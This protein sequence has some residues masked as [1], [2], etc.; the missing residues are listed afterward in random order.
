[1]AC[2]SKHAAGHE[3]E[4]QQCSFAA[5]FWREK[6]NPN[7]DHVPESEWAKSIPCSRQKRWFV[8]P[9]ADSE[10]Q[11]PYP[12][13][14]PIWEYPP[15]PPGVCVCGEGGRSVGRCCARYIPAH[16]SPWLPSC[17][18]AWIVQLRSCSPPLA[19]RGWSFS[20]PPIS[21]LTLD[22]EGACLPS[23]TRHLQTKG[24]VEF[25]QNQWSSF[26]SHRTLDNEIRDT[27]EKVKKK[28]PSINHSIN[29]SFNQSTHQPQ[30][31]PPTNQS[32]NKKSEKN[33]HI[34][35]NWTHTAYTPASSVKK[36]I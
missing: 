1:M 33:L 10:K 23:P 17:T 2:L 26:Y 14:R 15:S 32:K 19:K 9:V 18:A 16:S 11:K 35:K 8:D 5:R 6:S 3:R 7:P 28:N 36:N 30:T 27:K 21:S 13:E 22:Y 29:R 25:T 4:Q 34:N 12:V 31:N 20:P 24:L